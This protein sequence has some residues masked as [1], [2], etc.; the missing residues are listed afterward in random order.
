MRA[1][2]P[3]LLVDLER[4][5]GETAPRFSFTS[6]QAAAYGIKELDILEDVLRRRDP[7]TLRLVAERIRAKIGFRQPPDES[8]EAFLRA[9]YAV[10]RGR[11]EHRLLFGHRRKDKF[12]TA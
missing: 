7:R 5:V 9:Y 2:R 6:D 3:A 10:L 11:L 1:P 12:D 4:D 8:D